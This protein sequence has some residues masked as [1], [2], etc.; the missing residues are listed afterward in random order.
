MYF[1]KK[2]QLTYKQ[3]LRKLRQFVKNLQKNRFTIDFQ[4]NELNKM[5]NKLLKTYQN[6]KDNLKEY[7]Q[8][9]KNLQ[10]IIEHIYLIF[11]SQYVK[12]RDQTLYID[13][14]NI[15]SRTFSI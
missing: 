15:S 14:H 7:T 9:H 11:N 4:N 5:Q 10:S 2:E 3:K 8:Y 13:P 1:N 12:T 6:R